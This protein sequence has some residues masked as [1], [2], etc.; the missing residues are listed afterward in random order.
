MGKRCPPVIVM[1]WH[2][3]AEII[4]QCVSTEAGKISRCVHLLVLIEFNCYT[5]ILWQI[6]TNDESSDTQLNEYPLKTPAKS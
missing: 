4:Y 2:T 3:D 6:D 1:W 5:E